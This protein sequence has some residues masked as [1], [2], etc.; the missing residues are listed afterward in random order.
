LQQGQLQVL[1]GDIRYARVR[2]ALS[3]RIAFMPQ[4]LGRN[5]YPTLSVYENVDFFARLFG[6]NVTQRAARID[7]LLHATGLAPFAARAAGK[8]SGGMKQKLSLCCAL[9]HHPDLLLLDEPTTGVDPLSRRQFWHLVDALRAEQ[10]TMTVMVATA[11]M[12]EAQRFDHL[13]ALDAGHILVSDTTATVMT[14]AGAETLEQAYIQMLAP[15]KR[16]QAGAFMITP[17]Q[18]VDG[19]PAIEATNL[20]RRFGDFV[21]VDKVSFRIE[22]G[23][24][25]G[26]LGSNGCGKTTTMKMLT[27]L[28]DASAG[29]AYLLGQAVNA[30]DMRTRMKVGYM[31]QAFS[32]YEELSVRK[33]LML[34]AKLYRLEG[35]RAQ[36]AV[37]TALDDFDL[38]QMADA[39]PTRLSL[40]MRQRL[41]LAAA[42]LHQP[43]VLILDEPTSGVDPAARDRFWR[44]LLY[45]SRTLQ[46]TIFVS[47][48]FMNEAQR[49]DRISFMHRGRVLAVGTPEA[50]RQQRQAPSLEAAFIAYL[51]EEEKAGP[52]T[53]VPASASVKLAQ[54]AVTPIS[55]VATPVAPLRRW[56]GRMWAFARR[57]FTELWRDPMRLTFA[58]LGPI[59]LLCS[60]A[61]SVSFDVENI[62][63]AVLDRDQSADSRQFLEHFSGSRYFSAAAPLRTTADIDALLRAGEVKL[64][65]DIPPRFGQDLLAGRQPEIGFFIDGAQPFT[66]E[67]IRGYIAGIMLEYV[68]ALQRAQPQP[69]A[70]ALPIILQPR[71][72]YNQAFRS[73]YAVTPGILML[74]L[75]LIPSM[76]TALGVVREKEMG[77]IT[78][79]YASPAT[80]GQYLLGK[81]LPYVGLAMLSYGSLVLLCVGVL[82]VPLKGGFFSLSL[83]ALAFVLAATALGLL[84]ST[85]VHSQVA[86]IFGAAILCLI[87]AVSFSGLLYPIS[88]LAG[89]GYWV[90]VGFPASWFQLISLGAFTKGLD[91][92]SFGTMYVALIAFA[93]GYLALARLLLRK[94]EM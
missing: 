26:F 93:L 39:Q 90:A 15:E 37:Q 18:I 35:A 61:W 36:L 54:A 33:N 29:S 69:E 3:A 12:E 30:H 78:N 9:V 16:G 80:V 94:Q 45:L 1:G 63:Y 6:L 46:V 21:A 44:H 22:R 81:Q 60:A 62:R 79:L 82:G 17:W 48:H 2:Q 56:W 84:V 65:M 53:L 91:W 72:T 58:L 14:R 23:E 25:F 10:P 20:T 76:L 32:L 86:A 74:A 57:E 59:V 5:L 11:Y 83:G 42:C 51:Q 67:N 70:L 73:I 64:V 89:G 88:T 92:R 28:L 7:Q 85:F 68:A 13:V 77:S 75:I 71:F 8:L 19:P 49:C 38:A 43:E 47:T 4:G 27:G 34:H 52:M 41:Q 24:I 50:L 66:A 31:S 55:S 87:P 40:G